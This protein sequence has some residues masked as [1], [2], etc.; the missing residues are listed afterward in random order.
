LSTDYSLSRSD[1]INLLN[2]SKEFFT[3]QDKFDEVDYAKQVFQD[4]D[5]VEKF[6]KYIKNVADKEGFSFQEDFPINEHA[7]K[8]SSGIF[9]SILKLDKNFHVYIH[10]NKDRIQRGVEDDGRKYYKLYYDAEN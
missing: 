4:E 1:Q 7:V 2:R 6:E 8:K 5:V 10:G 3:S 9:K